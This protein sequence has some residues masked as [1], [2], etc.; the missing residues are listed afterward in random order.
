MLSDFT[1]RSGPGIGAPG[2][3]ANEISAGLPG[4]FSGLPDHHQSEFS[5]GSLE[6]RAATSRGLLH[7]HTGT[8]RQDEYSVTWDADT[9]QLLVVVCDGVGSLPD[10][11]ATAAAICEYLP[12]HFSVARDLGEAVRLSNAMLISSQARGGVNG[13]ST[14]VAAAIRWLEGAMEVDAVAVGDSSAWRLDPA[15]GAWSPIQAPSESA[16]LHT[17]SVRPLPDPHLRGLSRQRFVTRHPVFLMSD[18]VSGPLSGSAQVAE[19]LAGWWATPPQIFEF[20]A[21]VA[22]ARKSHQDDRTVVG[23]WP[24][25]EPTVDQSGA[26]G[27]DAGIE[28]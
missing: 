12:E 13:A 5:T 24:V 3:A 25:A 26:G 7:R 8:G 19:T 2:R 15:S 20:G 11:H 21:Q 23:V 17:T 1:T 9:E 4:Q 28:V 14:V 27:D 6:I 16:S 22:F 18:G 10:S